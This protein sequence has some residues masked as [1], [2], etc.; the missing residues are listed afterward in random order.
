[1]SDQQKIAF[2]LSKGVAEWDIPSVGFDNTELNKMY[3]KL[4]NKDYVMSKED[5]IRNLEHLNSKLQQDNEQGEIVL[6]GGAVMCLLYGNRQTTRDI[7]A[8]FEPK[9]KIYQKAK[10][11]AE[12][13][14]FP[15][16]W[17][18][19]EVKGFMSEK[20]DYSEFITMSN[21]TVNVATPEYMLA[22]KC[23]SSRTDSDSERSDIETLLKHLN[24][25]TWDQVE[26][27]IL[28]YYPKKR[29]QTK[30]R[31]FVEEIIDEL[32]S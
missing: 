6:V 4:K 19:D 14:D 21:L 24:L 29:F 16:D 10:E 32:L 7:D 11:I 17:L 30:T 20:A 8:I 1:M 23:L 2:L 27:I 12:E 26:E 5:L 9:S 18:N 13:G 28:R 31:F 22:M 15:S 25:K 3:N